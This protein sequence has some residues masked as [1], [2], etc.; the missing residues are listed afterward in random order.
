[1]ASDTKNKKQHANEAQ[2]LEEYSPAMTT[3]PFEAN[4]KIHNHPTETEKIRRRNSQARDERTWK[5]SPL[6]GQKVNIQS[7]EQD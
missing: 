4:P 5:F 7:E 1:M 3:H 2:T 6:D